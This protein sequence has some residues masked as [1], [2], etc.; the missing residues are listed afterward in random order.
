MR[1]AVLHGL[2]DIRLE[3]V[4]LPN[5]RGDEVVVR[6]LVNGLCGSDI[7][8]FERGRLGPFVV[9]RPYIPGHEASGVVVRAAADGSGPPEGTRVTIE[10]G[11][12]CRRCAECKSGRYN[13]CPDVVFMSAPPVNGTFTEQVAVV[14]DFVHPL[15]DAMDDEIGAFVEPVSVGVQACTRAG[16]QA[17]G[18]VVVLGAGPIGLITLLVA[19]AFG[20]ARL[21]VVDRIH[22][23]L[24]LAGR[25]GALV[26]DAS[27]P[28]IDV[29]A[30]VNQ[31]T[32]GRNAEVVFDATGSSAACS[33]APFLA[34]RGGSVTL[35]GWPETSMPPM[36]VDVI[37]ER[38]LDL[39]GVNRY[40]NTY[41]R[42]IALMAAG[43]I[44]PRPLVS[45]RYP[46]A[47]VC[48]AFDFASL[49]REE[50]I[51]VLVENV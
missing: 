48:E 41:P 14:T 16:L 6:V 13:L 23:R 21:I 40:C 33:M 39:H 42:A 37:M 9:D 12:P 51:K 4:P 38:E 25:L 43:A 47:S 30:E 44:D 24:V 1:A 20:A 3:D 2:R 35:I 29:P 26:I 32:D 7:H 19:R 17:G 31:M 15:P 34:A 10:P 36:P 45:H 8:F 27:K 5:P 49:H 50:T 11:I 22:S 46:F 18:T 28:G